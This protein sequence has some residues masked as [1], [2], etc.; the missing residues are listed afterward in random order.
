MSVSGDNKVNVSSAV[1]QALDFSDDEQ[2][3]DAKRKL[4]NSRRKAGNDTSKHTHAFYWSQWSNSV[5]QK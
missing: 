5:T 1:L 3:H 4:K 2:E